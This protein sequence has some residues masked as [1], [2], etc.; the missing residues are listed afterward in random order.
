MRRQGGQVLAA[1]AILV[2]LALLPIAAYAI[3]SA[4]LAAVQ[5]ALQEAATRAAE[6][7]AGRLDTARLRAGTAFAV[8]PAAAA[9]VARSDVQAEVPAAVLDAVV[10]SGDAVTLSA[11]EDVRLDLGG[12]LRI[13]SARIR[14]QVAARLTPGYE[15]PSSRL[16]LSSSSF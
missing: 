3:E 8:D 13:G 5:A 11:H 15:S 7:A 4:R 2:P 14:V 1:V 16:P 6:D 12:I 9:S 10:V